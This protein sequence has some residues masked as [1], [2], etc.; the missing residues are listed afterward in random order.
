MHGAVTAV[1]V[2]NDKAPA[3]RAVVVLPESRCKLVQ[4]VQTGGIGVLKPMLFVEHGS[5]VRILSG[6]HLEIFPV[7]LYRGAQKHW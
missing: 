3:S 4:V 7:F 1:N 5:F 2:I 6:G